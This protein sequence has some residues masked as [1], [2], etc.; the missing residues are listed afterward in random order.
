[1]QEVGSCGSVPTVTTPTRRHL[2]CTGT[3]REGI[4]LSHWPASFALRLS[5]AVKL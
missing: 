2:T 5:L 3:L 1:M 4:F